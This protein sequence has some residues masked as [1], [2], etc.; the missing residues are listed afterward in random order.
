M[1][2]FGEKEKIKADK[3]KQGYVQVFIECEAINY[4]ANRK[5][6]LE[7]F[8]VKGTFNFLD[9]RITTRQPELL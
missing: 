2:K 6:F 7:K 4:Y 1:R 8:D 5:D 3:S 9:I